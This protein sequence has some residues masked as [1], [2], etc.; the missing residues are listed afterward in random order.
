MSAQSRRV[1]RW[2]SVATVMLL[3]LLTGSA[4]AGQNASGQ[5]TAGQPRP[6]V[7]TAFLY[8]ELYYLATQFI[9]RTAGADG[10]VADP[11]DPNNLPANYNGAQEFYKW[12]GDELTNPANDHMGPLGR[13][14][15]A[16]DHVYP[17][18]VWQLDDEIVT[19]PGQSCAG[20]VALIAG[21]ND[22][23][24]TSTGVAKIGRAHV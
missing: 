12:F 23:T 2:F 1:R 22:S 6:V 24:P 14:M 9:F 18:R 19:L 16:K 3:A 4:A 11:S 13:F 21:H 15:T 5:T 20:Q 8:N 10:P 7:D 17:T